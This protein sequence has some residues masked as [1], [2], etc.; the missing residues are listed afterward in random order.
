MILM[1][2]A[3]EE[4]MV[5]MD[6]HKN[7]GMVGPQLL[8][9]DGSLQHSA[10]RFMDP[11]VILYRRIPLLRSLPFAK[12]AVDQYLMVGED[13]SKIRDVDYILGAAMFV[14][15]SALEE[16]GGFDPEFFVYFEDQDWCRRFWEKS[17]RVVYYPPVQLIHYH[18]RETAQGGFFK[19]LMNPLTRIQIKS[20]LYYYKKYAHSKHGTHTRISSQDRT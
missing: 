20:A 16:V 18:R 10:Y 17:W 9:P 6:S 12:E 2:G 3:V 14:R 1:P 15:R 8:N 5:F 7:V 19:Q 13:S 4:L 11:R